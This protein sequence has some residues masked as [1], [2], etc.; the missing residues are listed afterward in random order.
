MWIRRDPLM[1]RTR[2]RCFERRELRGSAHEMGIVWKTA[3]YGD[4]AAC[5]DT[6]V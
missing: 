3:G 6:V 4:L 5:N 1:L 2:L